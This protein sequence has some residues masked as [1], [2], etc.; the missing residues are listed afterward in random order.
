MS[1]DICVPI[2]YITL[3]N[4]CCP[5]LLLCSVTRVQKVVLDCCKSSRV[6]YPECGSFFTSHYCQSCFANFCFFFYFSWIVGIKVSGCRS[7]LTSAGST[8]A[9]INN[10]YQWQILFYLTFVFH[11]NLPGGLCQCNCVINNTMPSRLNTLFR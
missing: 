10:N 6:I 7:Y 11:C 8:T 2:H 3:L 5:S 9:S 4:A 1:F